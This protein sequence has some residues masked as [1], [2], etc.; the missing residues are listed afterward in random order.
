MVQII[1]IGLFYLPT[2][3]GHTVMWG[4]EWYQPITFKLAPLMREK[5]LASS[6]ALTKSSDIISTRSFLISP[7]GGID[8][9]DTDTTVPFSLIIF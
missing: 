5:C 6:M 8:N 7:R 9:A 2:L 1:N 4:C 3:D